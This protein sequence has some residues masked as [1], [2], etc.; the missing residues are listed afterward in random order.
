MKQQPQIPSTMLPGQ[1]FGSSHLDSSQGK[2]T[3]A[4]V[5]DSPSSRA[6][7]NSHP[8]AARCQPP[9]PPGRLLPAE[10]AARYIP[11]AAARPG[12]GAASRKPPRRAADP[13]V[14]RLLPA[15]PASGPPRKVSSLGGGGFSQTSPPGGGSARCPL[16]EAASLSPFVPRPPAPGSAA[17]CVRAAASAAAVA[18]G[19]VPLASRVPT[20]LLPHARPAP[21]APSALPPLADAR[22]RAAPSARPRLAHWA[23]PGLARPLPSRA[24]PAPDPGA[25]RGAAEARSSLGPTAAA[26]SAS[27]CTSPPPPGAPGAE[28]SGA[29]AP[30]RGDGLAAAR[31]TPG[32]GRERAPRR[33]Q[34][35][36]GDAARSRGW[37]LAVP[38]RGGES[39]LLFLCL[40][41]RGARG[42]GTGSGSAPS[43]PRRHGRGE[44]VAPRPAP[45]R[46]VPFRSR[47]RAPGRAQ[48]P[49]GCGGA[50]A[51]P[52][53]GAGRGCPA[54]AA[55]QR[56]P[57]PPLRPL[58]NKRRC[59]RSPADLGTESR[60]RAAWCSSPAHGQK[61]PAAARR[62]SLW[63]GCRHC[64]Q[65]AGQ[66]RPCRRPVR[67][68][69]A[70]RGRPGAAAGGAAALAPQGRQAAALGAALALPERGWPELPAPSRGERAAAG[71]PKEWCCPRSKC[72]L[73]CGRQRPGGGDGRKQ[74]VVGHTG[75]TLGIISERD[76]AVSCPAQGAMAALRTMHPA[77]R[78][79]WRAIQNMK[80]LAPQVDFVSCRVLSLGRLA[81]HVPVPAVWEGGSGTLIEIITERPRYGF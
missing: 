65:P 27:P 19:S 13:S 76:A 55:A 31:G 45:F 81:L 14:P 70:G 5:P 51:E 2:Q 18:A 48:V 17:P 68:G 61:A 28:R 41:P 42:S 54:P 58:I 77:G 71:K 66:P 80:S 47:S 69:L 32:V 1:L 6:S 16:R 3:R 57:G 50:V 24:P 7:R 63:S 36:Q 21:S 64:P 75:Q 60:P 73:V 22:L 23:L 56:C 10:T 44:P 74:E 59:R 40:L 9:S 8:A 39:L 49:R 29:A 11:A 46:S 78:N 53:G 34:P 25:G 52:L 4:R 79:A 30:D 15:A 37:G 62:C 38:G 26:A 33:A 67:W 12:P 43:Q 72:C 35:Q 20:R